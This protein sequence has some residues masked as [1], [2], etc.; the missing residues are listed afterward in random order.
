MEIGEH[1]RDAA[2][3]EVMEETRATSV[4]DYRPCGFV[5]E[6]LV[7][8]DGELEAH[9]HIFLGS[10]RID[11]FKPNNR[12]GELRLFTADYLVQHKK[13]FLPSDW[14]MFTSY[15]SN[16]NYIGMYEAELIQ[17]GHVYTLAY[18]R[19]VKH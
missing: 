6:R 4:Q 3:R 9:F 2:I 5:S 13:E 19:E 15:I 10:A 8:L 7:N 17:D 18:Y 11:D 12:E 16:P 14:Y 1:I